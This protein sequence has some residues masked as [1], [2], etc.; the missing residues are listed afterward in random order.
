MTRRCL[1]I[2]CDLEYNDLNYFNTFNYLIVNFNRF[3]N[4]II[5]I[6]Y[7]D[8]RY[9]DSEINCSCNSNFEKNAIDLYI[10]RID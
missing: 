10:D 6:D 8:K 5:K 7:I 9:F 4:I 3:D 1:S 2:N